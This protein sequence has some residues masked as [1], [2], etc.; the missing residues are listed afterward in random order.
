MKGSGGSR[1]ARSGCDDTISRKAVKDWLLR[2]EGYIEKDIIA[3]MQ[4]RVIDIPPAQPELIEKAAYIR[5][6]EQGRTQGMIDAKEEVAQPEL[7]RCK[8]CRHRDEETGFCEG[9][10][11]PMQLVLDDGFCDKGERRE[12]RI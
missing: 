2:W 11:W 6:F 12:E 5:G 3:R 1:S 4:C 7:I 10:G 9:R 8:D